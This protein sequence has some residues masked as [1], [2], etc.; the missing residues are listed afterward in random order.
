MLERCCLRVSA[1]VSYQHT[2]EDIELFTGIRVSAKT[3]HRSSS[4]NFRGTLEDG[5]RSKRPSSSLCLSQQPVVTY[6]PLNKV[7]RTP[8]LVLG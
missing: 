4:E 7:T 2:A 6:F 5:A 3:Q 1:N 8:L